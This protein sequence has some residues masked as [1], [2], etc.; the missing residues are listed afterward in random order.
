MAWVLPVLAGVANIMET[1]TFI[2]FIQEEAIQSCA[3]GIFLAIRQK[4]Y[5]SAQQGLNVLEGTLCYHLELVNQAVGWLAPAS[6]GAFQD[7]ILATQTNI[8]IYHE[9]LTAAPR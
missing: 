7:F 9:L 6:K 2:Q 8:E 1:V 4:K 3:L 5:Y